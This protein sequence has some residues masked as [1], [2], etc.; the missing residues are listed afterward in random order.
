MHV[1]INRAD[2]SEEVLHGLQS[3]ASLWVVL[4]IVHDDQIVE[5][6]DVPG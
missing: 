2:R 6:V 5:R 1:D 4:D 3:I